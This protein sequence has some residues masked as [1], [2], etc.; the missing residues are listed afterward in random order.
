M[1]HADCTDSVSWEAQT[2]PEE[3]DLYLQTY[4]GLKTSPPF[5]FERTLLYVFELFLDQV[6]LQV[7]TK[8]T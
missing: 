2:A 4:W 7:N 5:T 8:Q 1:L 3:I 6:Y